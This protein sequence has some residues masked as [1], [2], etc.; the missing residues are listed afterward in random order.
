[1]EKDILDQ[2]DSS[3]LTTAQERVPKDTS[4]LTTGIIALPFSLGI[5]GIIL[6]IVTLVNASNSLRIYNANPS[7]YLSSSIKKVRAGRICAII[8]LSL[9][10]AAILIG[11]AVVAAS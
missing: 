11:I 2:N 3:T 1:M 10:A 9:F 8:S 6:S 5:I 4:I 7:R